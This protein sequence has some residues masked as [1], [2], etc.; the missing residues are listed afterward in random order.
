MKKQR[1]AIT[2]T[3]GNSKEDS[4]SSTHQNS[5]ILLLYTSRGISVTLREV[6]KTPRFWDSIGEFC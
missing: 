2:V 1:Q 4:F 3:R 6:R 5:R